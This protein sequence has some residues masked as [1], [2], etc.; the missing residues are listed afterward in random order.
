MMMIYMMDK[1]DLLVSSRAFLV[2]STAVIN[3]E[4]IGFI[5]YIKLGKLKKL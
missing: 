3:C 1:I 4:R 5:K 2:S